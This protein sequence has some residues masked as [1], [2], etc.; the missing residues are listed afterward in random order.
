MPSRRHE[1]FD[2]T[3]FQIGGAYKRAGRRAR[4]PCSSPTGWDEGPPRGCKLKRS[5]RVAPTLDKV[6]PF[7]G[8]IRAEAGTPVHLSTEVALRMD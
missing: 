5:V 4:A 1:T 7:P 3:G 2:I 6:R 8:L